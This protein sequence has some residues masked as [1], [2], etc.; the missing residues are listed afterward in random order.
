MRIRTAME[1]DLKEI[2]KIEEKCFPPAEAA[3]MENFRE[4]LRIYPD[5]F[6]LLEQEGKI[7]SFINGMVTNEETIQDEMFENARLH[8][9]EGGWQA[10]FGV[11]TLPRYQGKGY[12]SMLMEQVIADAKAQ[13]RKGCILTC[14]KELIP[15]YERFG[16]QNEG[17]SA[18]V[19]GNAVWYDMRL[20]F[21]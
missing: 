7:L 18:S 13:G 19:H 2:T 16:Y 8:E 11:N 10:I 5:H 17:I 21:N 20:K 6:W 4:R 12:A 14:K 15:F 1:K 3:S 9:P